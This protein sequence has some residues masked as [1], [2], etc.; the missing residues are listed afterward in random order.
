M[1]D[2]ETEK[3]GFISRTFGY[4]ADKLKERTAPDIPIE[5]RRINEEMRSRIVETKEYQDIKNRELRNRQIE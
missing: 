2:Q 5:D 3:K 1:T 4:F